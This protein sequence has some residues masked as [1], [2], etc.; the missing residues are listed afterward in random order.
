MASEIRVTNIKANDGTASL[1]V[2]DSTGNVSVGGTLT[3]TG[4]ITASG[5]IANAGT[6]TAGTIGSS[7]TGT[8][9]SNIV[10]PAGHVLQVKGVHSTQQTSAVTSPTN[11]WLKPDGSGWNGSHT[12]AITLTT[13]QANSSF[14]LEG[15]LTYFSSHST[16]SGYQVFCNTDAFISTTVPTND[17]TDGT[18]YSL[19]DYYEDCR[20][21][22]N[23]SGQ[24]NN[25]LAGHA[26][27]TQSHAAGTTLYFSYKARYDRGYL[28]GDCIS[29]IVTEVAT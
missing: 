19:V 16:A 15:R 9:G 1:T 23:I 3:S 12:A 17:D 21:T 4:A 8:L 10:F 14:K 6:I 11:K 7:V 26:F 28:M 2:A 18:Q 29:F 27:V 20:S 22:N 5:G 13:K 25:M 24:Q